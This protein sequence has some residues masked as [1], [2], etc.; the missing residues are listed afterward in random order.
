MDGPI[1]ALG[2]YLWV[3]SR[4]TP[5]AILDI[6]FVAAIVFALLEAVQGTR[7]AVLLR[8]AL[9]LF[10][11]VVFA[12]TVLNLMTLSW[13]LRNA[14]PAMLIAVPIVFQPELRRGLERLGRSSNVIS[15]I[16]HRSSGQE[17]EMVDEVVRAVEELA[18]MRH[19]ALIVMERSTRLNDMASQG[20]TIDG[21]LSAEL[22]AN[23]FSPNSPLHDGAVILRQARVVAAAVVL[24]LGEGDLGSRYYGM[25]HRAAIGISEQTDAIAVVVSEETGLISLAAGGTISRGM[26]SEELRARLLELLGRSSQRHLAVAER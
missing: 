7:A 23:I 3:F 17:R 24:P 15:R 2:Y 9:I 6:L 16:V 12:S 13:V 1:S 14:L 5:S 21:K 8:G 22:L 19:G 20:I 11:I 25:R 4:L 10:L 18:R 26:D